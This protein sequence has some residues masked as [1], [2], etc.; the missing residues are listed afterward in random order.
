MSNPNIPDRRGTSVARRLHAARFV[1]AAAVAV[2]TH[3]FPA[4]RIR[5]PRRKS[6]V[7]GNSRLGTAGSTVIVPGVC[8]ID[9]KRASRRLSAS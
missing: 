6:S 5:Q 2:R 1:P 9:T 7:N 8:P 4:R 3:P